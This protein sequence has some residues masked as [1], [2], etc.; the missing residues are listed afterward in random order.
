[1]TTELT[2]YGKQNP[3]MWVLRFQRAIPFGEIAGDEICRSDDV[4]EVKNTLMELMES[5]RSERAR[6]DTTLTETELK[7]DI[8]VY[9]T[10]GDN[11]AHIIMKYIK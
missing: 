8:G 3:R 10:A 2:E 11:V 5:L 1:M 4:I 9:D 6:D 7:S